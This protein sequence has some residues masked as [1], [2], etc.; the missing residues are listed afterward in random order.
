MVRSQPRSRRVSK[1]IPFKNH[2]PGLSFAG[3]DRVL[4]TCL[5]VVQFLGGVAASGCHLRH[6]I[7]G[8]QPWSNGTR[9]TFYSGRYY[10]NFCKLTSTILAL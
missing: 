2:M 6:M 9:V 4:E 3:S 10:L 1:L 5:S 8:S 7:I